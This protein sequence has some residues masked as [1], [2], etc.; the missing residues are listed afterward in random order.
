MQYSDGAH[1]GRPVEGGD[2]LSE[3]FFEARMRDVKERL[4]PS[5][6]EHTLGVANTAV[7]LAH[8][9][10]ADV[11]SARLAGLL[12]DWD[13]SY[14]DEG[15]RRRVR[16]LGVKVDPFVYKEMPALLHGPTA[17]CV[18]ARTYPALPRDVI[19]AIE[20]H[21][22]AACNMTGL[23]MIVYIADVIEPGRHYGDLRAVRSLIGKVPL[24]ELFVIT[25]QHVLLDLI[26]RHKQIFPKTFEIWNY[27]LAH[28]HTATC[29]LKEKGAV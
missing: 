16:E 26:K 21:T 8:C 2:V 23:D 18:L 7:Q 17:A 9:Y 10:G 3:G 11:A 27:Y 6:F 20:V 14:D 5:R 24:E 25:F 22:T 19:H 12:H 13:K 28:V 4:T 15:I 29:T 1:E